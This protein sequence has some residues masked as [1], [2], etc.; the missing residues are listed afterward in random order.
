MFEDPGMFPGLGG[1]LAGGIPD[2]LMQPP[3]PQIMLDAA[4]GKTPKVRR[5]YHAK[6]FELTDENQRA[7]YEHVMTTMLNGEAFFVSRQ[8]PQFLVREPDSETRCKVLLEWHTEKLIKPE[9]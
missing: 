1:G 6:I 5:S 3:D 8:E 9:E 4:E 7:E 2:G